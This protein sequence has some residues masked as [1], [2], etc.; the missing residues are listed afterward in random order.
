M[1]DGKPG[2]R[3]KL[4]QAT[5]DTL[6]EQI[7]KGAFLAVA[8]KSIGIDEETLRRWA[9]RGQQDLATGD[10]STLYAQVAKELPRRAAN[11]ELRLA[12]RFHD[13]AMGD[14]DRGDWRAISKI[15]AQRYPDRWAD[16]HQVQIDQ[17]VEHRIVYEE[18][19]S[20]LSGG[21]ALLGAHE[22]DAEASDAE[23][24]GAAKIP[25]AILGAGETVATA[26]P[27]AS[28]DADGGSRF[29]EK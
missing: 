19:D 11:C 1:A 5:L 22:A 10:E 2:P 8:C 3:S 12:G 17:H 20:L 9:I 25:L 18:L 28:V 29:R 7:D 6:L 26:E 27:V 16:R 23:G 21:A 15:L 24:S 14:S 13:L 4:T